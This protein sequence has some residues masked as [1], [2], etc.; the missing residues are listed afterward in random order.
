M[1]LTGDLMGTKRVSQL[2][3]EGALDAR[4][5]ASKR[6]IW[7]SDSMVALPGLASDPYDLVGIRGDR[8]NLQPGLLRAICNR[9]GMKEKSRNRPIGAAGRG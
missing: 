6:K 4:K 9:T 1:Q 8:F 7:I 5:A 3:A 2:P